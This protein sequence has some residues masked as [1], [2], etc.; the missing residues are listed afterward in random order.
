MG[1]KNHP[2][3]ILHIGN[4]ANN[5]YLNAKFL[6]NNGYDCDVICYDYY[7]IMACPEWEEVDIDKNI[8]DDFKPNWKKISLGNFKRPKW[9]AQ[10]SKKTCLK[11]LIEKRS[12]SNTKHLNVLF[13]SLLLESNLTYSSVPYFLRSKLLFQKLLR[14]I[15]ESVVK[16]LLNH[17]LE[18]TDTFFGEIKKYFAIKI[19]Y[20]F[21]LISKKI[22]LFLRYL[23]KKY[24]IFINKKIRNKFIPKETFESRVNYLIDKFNKKFPDRKD[25]LRFSDFDLYKSTYYHWCELISKYDL[26]FGY[27]TDPIYPLLANS[28]PYVAFEH[29]T[30][31]DLPFENSSIGRITALSYSEASVVY[32]T[33]A[34]S[35]KQ[36]KYLNNRNVI[37]GLHG[38]DPYKHIDSSQIIDVFK[39]INH[40]IDSD[41]KIFFSPS[42]HQWKNGSLNMKKGNDFIV[43][44][45][46]K[47]AKNFPNQFRIIF[48][49]WGNEVDLT[50][51]LI[52]ELQLN[53]YFLWIKPLNKKNLLKFFAISDCILDQFIVP[54]I[55]SVSLDSI[56]IGNCP[57]IT[58]LDDNAMK[59]FY[60]ETIPLFNCKSS[61]EIYKAF[62]LII[63][64]NEI[65]KEKCKKSKEWF[66]RH[67]SEK[68]LKNFL[69]EA[70]N[71]ANN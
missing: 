6:N 52:S 25:K 48:V 13:N 23:T 35:I 7:H 32:M 37:F 31:R 69:F 59:S 19:L 46:S 20:A 15:K 66:K 71:Q 39:L 65:S 50:K 12:S 64:N 57:V 10:G 38:F 45:A 49:E 63:T 44:A 29:G 41:K 61:F 36:A 47:L 8:I 62:K 21:Q 60:G 40:K 53:D 3:K 18:K 55:G 42:R 9:F 26:V 33:N 70:I 11:Y 54:C 17:S 5:A 27:A 56:A 22:K 2:L 58:K 16:T 1:L 68:K 51:K 24:L 67:H 30:I 34:D 4:I 43:R 14:E 28:C